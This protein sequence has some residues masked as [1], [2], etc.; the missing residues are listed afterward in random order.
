MARRK[1]KRSKK[2][3]PAI[4]TFEFQIPAG[5]AYAYI[6]LSQCAS[7]LNRR[8]YRQGLEWAVAGFTLIG[9]SGASA[10]IKIN[11]VPNSWMA[12]NAWHKGF[13]AW[14]EMNEQA[15][16]ENPSIKPAFYDFKV[17]MTPS[18]QSGTGP[19]LL[20]VDPAGN[21]YSSYAGEWVHSKF[22]PSVT[23][24]ATVVDYDITFVGQDVAGTSV[25]LIQ[26]YQQSRSVPQSPD[27]VVNADGPNSIFTEIF[28]EG[29]VQDINILDD[30]AVDNDEL[31]YNQ[32]QYVGTLGTHTET[33]TDLAV[34][35]TTI[36]AKTSGSGGT[37]PCGLI[38]LQ[39]GLDSTA[40]LYV[41]LVRGDHR[42]YMCRP[43]QDM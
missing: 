27:P 35:A 31:P 4:E 1:A 28:D 22:T 40:T 38:E 34:S 3:Q 37:F 25:G 2:L 15:M 33:V 36:G 39:G 7:L 21:S 10:Q 29:T 23:G 11:R 16:A 13:A 12:S 8:F 17:Y 26:N 14:N 18:Q 5:N 24:G 19:T 6:D 30:L 42:G 9:S 32:S 43:M 41:H 20:P